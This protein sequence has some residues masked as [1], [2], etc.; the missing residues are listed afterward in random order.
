MS[1][2]YFGS[3]KISGITQ[4]DGYE[5][6]M[7]EPEDGKE[8]MPLLTS[9]QVCDECIS[10][11]PTQDIDMKAKVYDIVAKDFFAVILKH[12]ITLRDIDRSTD[13]FINYVNNNVSQ[14]LDK[15][16]GANEYNRTVQQLIKHIS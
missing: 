13:L 12:N 5:M 3:H 7:F 10:D 16:W 9:K 1:N 15:L 8:I 4:Q 2:K 6:I 14:A 11:E